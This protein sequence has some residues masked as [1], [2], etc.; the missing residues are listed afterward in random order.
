MPTRTARGR[1]LLVG[2]VGA[3]GA[4]A[5]PATYTRVAR[6]RGP[7]VGVLGRSGAPPPVTPPVTP[8]VVWGGASHGTA[9]APVRPRRPVPVT[10][11]VRQTVPMVRQDAVG[12][13]GPGRARPDDDEMVEGMFV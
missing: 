3:A 11:R 13:V 8:P 5:P 7:L 1:G 9:P 10:G 2:L 12:Q 4:A 6:G